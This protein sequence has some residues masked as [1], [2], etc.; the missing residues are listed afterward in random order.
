[1]RPWLSELFFFDDLVP[2][3]APLN[4]AIDEALLGGIPGP[5]LRVYRWERPAVSFGYFER[6]APIRLAHPDR[7]PVR[8]W[9]G[10]G[11][12]LHGEDLTYSLLIPS[13]AG[14]AGPAAATYALVHGALCAALADAGIPAATASVSVEKISEACFENPVRHDVL[15]HGRKVAGAAQ[16]RTRAGLIH[17]GSI[18]GLALPP[19]FGS[20][21]AA[22]LAAQVHEQSFDVIPTAE[23]LSAEKYGTAAW[24]AK[25]L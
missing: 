5:V 10:G 11:I 22:R 9:T 15:V 2:H 16:R 20:L 18:Q 6:W 21:F 19:G 23:I 7:E 1:V 25:R 4:M 13:A 3:G 8:R 14:L 12:V 17:Q 24:L